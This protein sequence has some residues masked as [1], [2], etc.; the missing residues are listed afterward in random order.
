MIF[1]Y[2]YC[3]VLHAVRILIYS[4]RNI[5]N[6]T[7]RLVRLLKNRSQ[8]KC[9]SNYSRYLCRVFKCFKVLC[10][11]GRIS[12]QFIITYYTRMLCVLPVVQNQ[13]RHF[14]FSKYK[15]DISNKY[16]TRISAL[17][18]RFLTLLSDALLLFKIYCLYS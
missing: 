6:G 1:Y 14:F 2:T 5:F 18:Y 11:R 15:A 13:Q 17:R 9:T 16:I 10:W 8:L 4:I 3:T 7:L 12:G